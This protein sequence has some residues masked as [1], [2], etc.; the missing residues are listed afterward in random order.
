MHQT[1]RSDVDPV[2]LPT[3]QYPSLPTISSQSPGP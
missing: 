3:T 1:E 2:S